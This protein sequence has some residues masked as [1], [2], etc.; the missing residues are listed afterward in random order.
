MAAVGPVVVKALAI[1]GISAV[2]FVGV[3]SVVSELL[4]HVTTSY[5]GMSG[6]MAQIAGLAGAGQAIGLVLGAINARL[7]LWAAAS[8]TKWVTAVP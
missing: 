5:G 4:A 8:A 7:A 2:T 6:S 3:D 1:L